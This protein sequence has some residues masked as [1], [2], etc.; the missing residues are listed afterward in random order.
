M[1]CRGSLALHRLTPG[2][3]DQA[4]IEEAARRA[5]RSARQTVNARYCLASISDTTDR[6]IPSLE[7]SLRSDAAVHNPPRHVPSPAPTTVRDHT[8]GRPNEALNPLAINLDLAAEGI[9]GIL[10]V[11][12]S[13]DDSHVERALAA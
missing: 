2:H 4:A 8:G 13:P 3:L 6:P 11:D 9:N 10:P 1:S 12:R 7:V 5:S